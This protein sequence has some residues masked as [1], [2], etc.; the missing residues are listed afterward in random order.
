FTLFNDHHEFEPGN[1]FQPDSG[2]EEQRRRNMAMPDRNNLL[3]HRF[4]YYDA[5]K[6]LKSERCLEEL[7]KE[8]F[9]SQRRLIDLIYEIGDL[10]TEVRQQRPS[11]RELEKMYPWLNWNRVI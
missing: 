8:F 9:L 5:I 1:Q 2:S 7:E 10:I 4:Y 6:G 3:A 11:V